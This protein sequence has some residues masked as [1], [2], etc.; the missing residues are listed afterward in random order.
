MVPRHNW[1]GRTIHGRFGCH[2]WSGRTIYGCH[3]WSA[4]P[5]VVP[6]FILLQM[7]NTDSLATCSLPSIIYMVKYKAAEGGGNWGIL[8]WGPHC[9][10]TPNDRYTLIEQSNTLLKQSPH[11]C[12]GP[13]KFFWRPWLH[14]WMLHGLSKRLNGRQLEA[15]PIDPLNKRQL[16]VTLGFYHID[17][18]LMII[19]CVETTTTEPTRMEKDTHA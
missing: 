1:S 13:L 18:R 17:A 2:R 11:I 4:L 16:E 7:P 10:W 15:T 3:E 19:T 14:E 8:P 9:L 5:Q 12:P 6:P